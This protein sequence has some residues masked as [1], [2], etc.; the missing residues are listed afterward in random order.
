MVTTPDVS[1]VVAGVVADGSVTGAV[2][3]EVGTDVGA[4]AGEGVVLDAGVELSVLGAGFGESEPP[5][6]KNAAAV[7]KNTPT[8]TTIILGESFQLENEPL[9]PDRRSSPLRRGS[10]SF[11]SLTA[12]CFLGAFDLP[13]FV[14]AVSICSGAYI[15]A[16]GAFENP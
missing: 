13:L 8:S 16:V 6:N 7:S 5:K 14:G 2:T 1:G 11:G 3:S 15:G 9:R 10:F 12:F 4:E